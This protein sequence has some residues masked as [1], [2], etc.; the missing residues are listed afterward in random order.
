MRRTRIF[1]LA[2]TVSAGLF[3]AACGSGETGDLPVPDV[4]PATQDDTQ[5]TETPSPTEEPGAGEGTDATTS[6]DPAG[7]ATAVD[8]CFVHLFEDED[9]DES[10]DHFILT[11]PGEYPSIENLPG[12]PAGWD[13]EAESIK[14][15]PGATVT[16]YE[17]EDFRGRSMELQPGTEIADLE[18]EAESLKMTCN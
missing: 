11:E 4:P 3:L 6:P 1:A 9:F 8:G 15:G 16:I 13:D 12:A 14:V 10:D 2:T 5:G 18:D 7:S 17:D